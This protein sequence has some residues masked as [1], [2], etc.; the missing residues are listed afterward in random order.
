MSAFEVFISYSHED[1]QWRRYLER[2]LRVYERDDFF[3]SWSDKK[4]KSGD[5][6]RKGIEVAMNDAKVG[7]LLVSADFLGSKFIRENELKRLLERKEENSIDL[8][9]VMVR[10]CPW[11]HLEWLESLQIH[12]R[13]ALPLSGFTTHDVEVRLSELAEEINQRLIIMDQPD[14]EA[15]DAPAPDEV[16]AKAPVV[17]PTAPHT[18]GL[19]FLTLAGAIH[20]VR[21][22]AHLVDDEEPVAALNTFRTKAQRTWLVV[23]GRRLFCLLD[24]EKTRSRRIQWHIPLLEA[25]PVSAKPRPQKKHSGVLN[26]GPKRNW[27]YSVKL[28]PNPAV[29]EGKVRE[30]LARG[31]R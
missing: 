14:E 30:L 11:R 10:P 17:G 1:D 26:I 28:F 4:L 19:G 29:L 2:F 20:E 3:R 27:L 6:W 25:D 15:V 22:R 16:E 31:R 18:D 12:P 24:S 9:P 8:F 7:V 13:G 5:D 21:T 23:T